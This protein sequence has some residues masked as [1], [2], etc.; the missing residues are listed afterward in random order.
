MKKK[1]LVVDDSGLARRLTRKILESLGHE[2]DE[3]PGGAEALEKYALGKPDVVILDMLMTGMYGLEVLQKLRQMDPE[4]MVVVATAD[5]Q[6]T[7]RD[8]VR[9][10]GAVAM[11]NKPVNEEELTEV[12]DRVWKGETSWN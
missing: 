9:E 1:I 5:I 4:A 3:A 11:V 2:V 7:T 10:A 8:H 6:R 12:L